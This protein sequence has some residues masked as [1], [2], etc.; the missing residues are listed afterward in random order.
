MNL[1]PIAPNGARR[2]RGTAPPTRRRLQLSPQKN[3]RDI[4]V[5]SP[6]ALEFA[7]CENR[8]RTRNRL[9]T[10]KK[11]EKSPCKTFGSLYD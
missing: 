8:E 7:T 10:N 9:K 2:G 6:Q 4:L 11:I 1:H 3:V 5:K